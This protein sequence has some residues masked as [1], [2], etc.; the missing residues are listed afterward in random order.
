MKKIK[1]VLLGQPNAGKSTLFNQISNIFVDVANYPGT[2][3]EY[4]KCKIKE[5][6]VE[7]EIIDTPG[8]YSF[9]SQTKAEKITKDIIY[10][11][12]PD[13]LVQ[14]VDATCLRR[15]LLFTM[16]IL[17]LK[18]PLIL[19]LNQMDRLKKIGK[20]INVK[21]LSELLEVLVI[22]TVA[23]KKKGI[24]KL[25]NSFLKEISPSLFLE[26][27][28]NK[29]KIEIIDEIVNQVEKCKKL[30]KTPSEKFDDLILNFF[31]GFAV[32]TITLV[33]FL[34]CVIFLGKFLER[35]VF[36]SLFEFLI[37]PLLIFLVKKLIPFSFLQDLLIGK[38][39]ILSRGLY[40]PIVIVTPY[41]ISLYFF[42]NILADSGIL[43][44]ISV[45]FNLLMENLGLSGKGII[46][47]LLG[48]G[49]RVTG[50]MATR[51]LK[52][53]KEQNISST[54]T[55]ICLPCTSATATTVSLLSPYGIKYIGFVYFMLTLTT[56]F[57][58]KFL[59]FISKKESYLILELPPYR[60]PQI[61]IVLKKTWIMV[62]YFVFEALP[63]FILGG[64]ILLGIFELG[65][66]KI[67]VNLGKPIIS[68]FLKLPE[69]FS[70]ALFLGIIRKDI[71]LIQLS[72][73]NYPAKE[74]AIFCIINTI[75]FPCV[76]TCF[77]LL[78]ERKMKVTLLIILGSFILLLIFGKLSSLLINYI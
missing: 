16:E 25:K 52:E 72:F 74:L 60:V 46:P 57:V 30:S 36:S 49:C 34:I 19:V 13:I 47:L 42:L 21:K 7:I 26:K 17:E 14:I 53:E 61:K 66:M 43:P 12:K 71:P 3:I 9:S 44:R 39:G 31:P 77:A 69:N 62:R 41:M 28:Q 51:I 38:Y 29:S 55:S 78:K 27:Y 35:K 45:F 8:C 1:V 70:V 33:L 37:N 75:F 6:D 10:L 58:G 5:N 32:F 50:V 73:E 18:I 64:T 20:C 2:T 11:E 23:T 63:V 22:P 68:D 67:L 76:A 40:V 65:L 48:L 15:S 24:K 59:S 4:E 54:L 56:L